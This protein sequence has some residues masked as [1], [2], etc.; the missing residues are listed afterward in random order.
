MNMTKKEKSTKE[1][2]GTYEVRLK[3]TMI[4]IYNEGS[5]MKAIEVKDP[6]LTFERFEEVCKMVEVKVFPQRKDC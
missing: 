6:N 4:Y 1:K 3:G 2:Y 5:L